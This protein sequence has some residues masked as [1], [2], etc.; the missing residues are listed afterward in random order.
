MR[1][2]TF[3]LGNGLLFIA[4][5]GATILWSR[6]MAGGALMP[7][8]WI[9]SMMWMRM[10]S[11]T[12]FGA[13][14]AFMGIWVVMMV[15]MMLPSLVPILSSYRRAAREHDETRV[16]RLTVLAGGGYFLVW[17]AYGAV[18][19]ALGVGL[20]ATEMRWSILARYVPI[21]AGVVLVLAGCA[22]LTAW[23]ARQLRRC[24]ESLACGRG[25]P[26]DAWRSL[27]QGLRLGGHCALC[28]TGF[29]I[30]LLATG[31]MSIGAA[32]V[33][34][35]ITIERVAVRPERAARAAGVLVIAAGTLSIARALS[36][37]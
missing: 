23:K 24:W 19:Y 5:A 33:A 21:A 3:L 12:W 37:L 20:A 1:E 6:S 18:A 10:P 11:Q 34:L 28:C 32:L 29:M 17:A 7:G 26:L 30:L 13:A 8:G 9:L 16:D 4:S 15:A 14:A 25:E 35:A 2:R 27:R 31:M 36:A 22:E